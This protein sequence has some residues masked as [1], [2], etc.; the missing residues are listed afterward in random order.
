VACRWSTILQNYEFNDR[1]GVDL[2]DRWR[3]I[4]KAA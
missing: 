1:S 3:N 2:K 4:Q